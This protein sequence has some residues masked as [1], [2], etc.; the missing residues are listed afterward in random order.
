MKNAQ[1]S[2]QKSLAAQVRSWTA[3]ECQF[4]DGG[5]IAGFAFDRNEFAGAIGNLT[6]RVHDGYA[7]QHHSAI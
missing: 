1:I 2:V 5:P 3:R 6:N 4:D 7:A